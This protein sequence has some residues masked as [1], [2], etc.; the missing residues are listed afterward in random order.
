MT[1]DLAEQ[2]EKRGIPVVF[3]TGYE[4]DTITSRFQNCRVLN[5]PVVRD[6]LESVLKEH[7]APQPPRQKA[8]A[9]R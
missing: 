5:K 1:Y 8:A 9:S 7:F 3:T 4:A 6:A 2:L